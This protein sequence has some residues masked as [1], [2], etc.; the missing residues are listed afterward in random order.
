VSEFPNAIQGQTDLTSLPV[1]IFQ[2]GESL[3]GCEQGRHGAAVFDFIDA[4]TRNADYVPQSLLRDAWPF[5]A[6]L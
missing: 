2:F 3:P 1:P 6:P 5:D 4:G